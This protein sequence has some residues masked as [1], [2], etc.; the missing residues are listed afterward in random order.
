M[1]WHSS[2]PEA[3]RRAYRSGQS[4]DG[5]TAWQAYLKRRSQPHPLQ[6][7]MACRRSPLQ[8]AIPQQMDNGVGL[9]LLTQLEPWAVGRPR[10]QGQ[11]GPML[12]AWQVAAADAPLS[13]TLGLEALAWGHALPALAETLPSEQWLGLLERLCTLAQRTPSRPLDN[14][15]LAGQLLAGELGLTLAYLLPE[16]NPCRQLAKDA[17]STLSAGLSQLLDSEGLPHGKHLPWTRPLLACWTRVQALGETMPEGCWSPSSETR[18]K[19]FVRHSL[20]LMRSDGSQAF[21]HRM[22]KPGTAAGA[23]QDLFAAALR[24]ARSEEDDDLASLIFSQ[25]R[26]KTPRRRIS[27]L[28]L[29]EANAHSEQAGL[30][31]LRR[32][33]E[34]N[35]PRL[36]VAY[37]DKTVH[38]ELACGDEVFWSGPWGLDVCRDGQTLDVVSGWEEICW[39][40]DEQMDY[41]EIEARLTG[42]LRIQRH[43]AL[44]HEDDFVF[45][46]DSLLG[47]Q[48]AN[49]EHRA[50]LPISDPVRFEPAEE[51]REGL[52]QGRSRRALILPLALPEWRCDPRPGSLAATEQG[53]EL[54]QSATGVALFSPLFID[55]DGRRLRRPCTWRQLTVAENLQAQPLDVAVGYR[56]MVGNQQW[57]IYRSLA[58]V[59]NRSVLGH[60]LITQ[61]LVARFET[62]GEVE[63]LVEIE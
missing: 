51:T 6:Q 48:S 11:L 32:G 3:V 63:A 22:K 44:A 45:L 31:V 49:L 1:I 19:R 61:L 47:T 7:L 41:L 13:A 53:L 30:A 58:P 33:W 39:Y 9:G 27:K 56:V 37:H 26:K 60:N 21:A 38:L 34:K 36:V 29:P 52:L 50:R 15:P 54:C 40:S 5:W 35:D 59:G 12:S 46:A 57:L 18:Y 14:D 25:P 2:A 4:Q 16:L 10:G 20:R 42:G 62:D 43:L 55:L 8:W 23:D 17:R 28:A 24:L